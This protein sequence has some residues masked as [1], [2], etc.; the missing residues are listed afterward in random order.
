MA[1]RVQGATAELRWGYYLAARLG[2]W[3][4]EDQALRATVIERDTFRMAQRPLVLVVAGQRW[5]VERLEVIDDQVTG[6]V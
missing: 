4:I 1:F 2:A 6:W 3:T 5:P